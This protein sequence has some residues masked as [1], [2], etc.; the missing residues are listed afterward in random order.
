MCVTLA[1]AKL[2]NTTLYAAEVRTPDRT[3]HVLGYQ[4]KAQ[5]LAVGAPAKRI[6]R[7]KDDWDW[8]SPAP[9][10]EAKRPV[11]SGNAMLLPFPA[12]P[13]SMTHANVLETKG[14]PN[15]L[16]DLA[17]AV[18]PKFRSKGAMLGGDAIA[19]SFSVQVFDT[20]IYTVVLASDARAI[21]GALGRVP[22]ERR[23]QLNPEIFEAYASW[24]PDWTMALCCFSNTEAVL[25]DPL[26]WWYEPMRPDRLFAPSLD[27]H[28]GGVPDLTAE[29]EIDHSVVF[30]T[31]DMEAGDDVYYKD[32]VPAALKPYLLERVVGDQFH[33]PSNNGDF[34][35]RTEDVRQGNCS[36]KRLPPPGAPR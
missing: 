19:K 4:N 31:F 16:K 13:G 9:R 20:G 27:S 2:S 7:G 3:V 33:G 15:I 36:P 30:G 23:P 14:C 18:R 28:T 35:A 32:N 10:P 8:E 29:V 24:Y 22:E 26:L 11:L 6:H 17:E 34:V 12:R 1:P 21:P 25:A 5:N